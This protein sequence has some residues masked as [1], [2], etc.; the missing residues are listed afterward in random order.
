MHRIFLHGIIN[1]NPLPPWGGRPH[2]NPAV[3]VQRDDFNPLPPWGGRLDHIIPGDRAII[4]SIHSL[5]GEGDVGIASSAGQLIK[6][7]STPSVGRETS[8]IGRGLNFL[9]DFNPLPPW[10]GR[11]SYRLHAY[12]ALNFNPLPP[13]GGRHELTIFFEERCY[14]NPLPPWGG[15]L[16]AELDAVCFLQ[17]SIHSLRGEGDGADVYQIITN[18]I[19][20]H[21]LRGEGDRLTCSFTTS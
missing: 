11:P 17:I 9:S 5:R 8:G 19:S 20:I 6:F 1:F 13:W 7:Q 3:T 4:I 15:R 21:S 16:V 2:T 12:R 18:N 10:G 14:F